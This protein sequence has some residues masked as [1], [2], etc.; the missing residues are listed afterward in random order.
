VRADGVLFNQLLYPA[1]RPLP[2]G[3]VESIAVTYPPR[4]VGVLGFRMHWMV[5][6]FALSVMFAMAL[7]GPFRKIA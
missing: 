3:A 6:F 4:A 5:V 7:R 2:D 1:E